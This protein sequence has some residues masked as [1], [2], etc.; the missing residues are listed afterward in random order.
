MTRAC[1]LDES[2]YALTMSQTRNWYEASFEHFKRWAEYGHIRWRLVFNNLTVA[3]DK[4]RTLW[5]EALDSSVMTENQKA[6][7]RA[8]WK[9]LH[10]DFRIG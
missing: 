5:P 9:P 3:L 4:A 1:I 7:L 2:Q 6:V 10:P 8:H